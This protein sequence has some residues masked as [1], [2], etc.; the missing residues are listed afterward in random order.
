M[1]TLQGSYMAHPFLAGCSISRAN[2]STIVAN[3]LGAALMHPCGL[4][5]LMTITG[6]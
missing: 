3:E 6:L 5:R 1:Y 4:A 2:C